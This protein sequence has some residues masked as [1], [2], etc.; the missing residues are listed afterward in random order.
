[1]CEH[2][3]SGNCVDC[4]QRD[5]SVSKLLEAARAVSH[6]VK[7]YGDYLALRKAI[8]LF[9]EEPVKPWPTYNSS[10]GDE[11]LCSCKHPYYRHFDSYDD[12][13]PIGCKYCQCSRFDEEPRT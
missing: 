10:F 2:R 9:D 12:M 5:E 6:V 11:K 3:N 8:A 13:N 7:N 4:V 1:M